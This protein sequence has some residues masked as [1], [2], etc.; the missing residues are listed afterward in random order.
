MLLQADCT[1]NNHPNSS[2]IVS[3]NCPSLCVK[4]RSKLMNV[5]KFKQASL[6]KDSP[7]MCIGIL[8][9]LQDLYY[10]VNYPRVLLEIL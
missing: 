1:R 10:I 8:Y 3:F 5:A 6:N 2:I 9:I 7:V 4:P